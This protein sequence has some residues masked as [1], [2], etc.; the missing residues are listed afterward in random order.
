[1]YVMLVRPRSDPYCAS[2][3][4]HFHV[5]AQPTPQQADNFDDIDGGGKV[6]VT[7]VDTVRSSDWRNESSGNVSTTFPPATL[8]YPELS[9]AISLT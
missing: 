3:H 9:L 2:A 6:L 8:T 4:F 1:M 5:N 7:P